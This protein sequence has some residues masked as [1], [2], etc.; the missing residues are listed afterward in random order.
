VAPT[1]APFAVASKI[2]EAVAENGRLTTLWD[3]LKALWHDLAFLKPAGDDASSWFLGEHED[4]GTGRPENRLDRIFED[5]DLILETERALD[6]NV[7]KA[8]A[9]NVSSI[10]DGIRFG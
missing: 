7:N 9:W 10:N 4:R 6:G 3:L 2:T 8:L 5:M 1:G